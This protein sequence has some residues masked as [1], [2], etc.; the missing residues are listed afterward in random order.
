MPYDNY[1]ARLHQGEAVLTAQEAAQWRSGQSGQRTVTV[2]IY[3]QDLSNDQIY[4]V[5]RI[6]NEELGEAVS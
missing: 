2:N 3:P 6:I 4:E 5:V 1:L